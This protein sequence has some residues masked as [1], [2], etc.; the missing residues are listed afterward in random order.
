MSHF[1]VGRII[2]NKEL[3]NVSKSRARDNLFSFSLL[4]IFF[5]STVNV[6]KEYVG[7]NVDFRFLSVGFLQT[8]CVFNLTELAEEAIAKS[9][10]NSTEKPKI[11]KKN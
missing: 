9:R 1:G 11:P 2:D 3:E 7:A 5:C 6:G 8:L 10:K 4:H